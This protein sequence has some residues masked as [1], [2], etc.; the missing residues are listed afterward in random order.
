MGEAATIYKNAAVQ[1]AITAGAK[2]LSLHTGDPAG[3]GA[4]ECAG[5]SYARVATVWSAPSAGSSTGAATLINVPP[6]TT[7]TY[8]GVWDAASGGSFWEGGVLPVPETY[9][10]AGGTYLLTPTLNATG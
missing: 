10:A 3:T 6:S 9:P 8:W 1:S 2:Y 7:I 4:N 5:G